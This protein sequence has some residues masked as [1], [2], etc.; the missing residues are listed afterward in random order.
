MCLPL[1]SVDHHHWFIRGTDKAMRRGL[2]LLFGVSGFPTRPRFCRGTR[3][4]L[5]CRLLALLNLAETIGRNAFLHHC[6][7]WC[8][9]HDNRSVSYAAVLQAYCLTRGEASLQSTAA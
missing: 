6:G 7:L 9:G 5:C 2:C 3:A 8:K 1:V 4:W